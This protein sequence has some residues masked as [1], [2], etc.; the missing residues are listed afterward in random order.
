M[1]QSIVVRDG[2]ASTVN[3]VWLTQP[4]ILCVMI[5]VFQKR[6]STTSSLSHQGHLLTFL[7]EPITVA[8]AFFGTIYG[9]QA[10]P[11]HASNYPSETPGNGATTIVVA[12]SGASSAASAASSASKAAGEFGG[13]TT[14]S[15]SSSQQTVYGNSGSSNSTNGATN[16]PN[17]GAIVMSNNGSSTTTSS[18]L[19]ISIVA[20]IGFFV[21]ILAY[22]WW[23]NFLYQLERRCLIIHF[24]ALLYISKLHEDSM[25][26]LFESGS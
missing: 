9:H 10:T 13:S 26:D 18:N 3:S 15:S 8:P 17:S 23:D 7:R 5:R 16:V 22:L 11:S 14:Y 6:T 21:A 12:A 25:I 2:A 1:I 4:A 24:N 19:Q 20:L